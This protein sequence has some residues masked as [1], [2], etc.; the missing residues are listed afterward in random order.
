[1]M[2]VARTVGAFVPEVRRPEVWVARRRLLV[3][4]TGSWRALITCVKS[5]KPSLGQ[6]VLQ[7]TGITRKEDYESRT[8][9]LCCCSVHSVRGNG[10]GADDGPHTV[11]L[12]ARGR[13]GC[14]RARVCRE[15]RRIDRATCRGGNP[16]RR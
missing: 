12:P 15:T 11:R 9:V 14:P 6:N 4:Y 13:R 3:R 7:R 2:R 8:I 5:V 10:A 1:M 16:G